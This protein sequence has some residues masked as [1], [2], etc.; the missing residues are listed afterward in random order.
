MYIYTYIYVYILPFFLPLSLP[1][2]LYLHH[3]YSIPQLPAARALSLSLTFTPPLSLSLSLSL[4]LVRPCSLSHSPP[5]AKVQEQLKVKEGEL[6]DMKAHIKDLEVKMKSANQTA[7]ANK[8][9]LEKVR[10][11]ILCT[12]YMN[13][14][15]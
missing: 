4:S 7:A 3:S 8:M 9:S 5:L 2:S 11:R 14:C 12:R 1:P 10:V 13:I 6:K 15:V